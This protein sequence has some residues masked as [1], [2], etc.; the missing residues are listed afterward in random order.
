LNNSTD[1]KLKFKY[2]RRHAFRCLIKTRAFVVLA[3]S[4]QCYKIR[5]MCAVM[6]AS[7]MVATESL[8]WYATPKGTCWESS[9]SAPAS[10][11]W[12][13]NG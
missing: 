12:N 13:L 9:L 6:L 10:S 7:E 4:K 3:E 1:V 8:Q 5:E 11:T 2:L